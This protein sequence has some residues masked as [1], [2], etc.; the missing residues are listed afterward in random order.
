MRIANQN[1]DFETAAIHPPIETILDALSF[2]LAR[3][4]ALNERIGSQHFRRKYDMSLNEWRVLGLTCALE[5]LS[6]NHLAEHNAI[7][8]IAG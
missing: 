1:T 4:N 2:R 5:P 7:W 3:L 8:L 6:F